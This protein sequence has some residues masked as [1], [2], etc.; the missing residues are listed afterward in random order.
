MSNINMSKALGHAKTHKN[1]KKD[2]SIQIS[3]N[4]KVQQKW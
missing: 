1:S 4:F 2:D 3:L